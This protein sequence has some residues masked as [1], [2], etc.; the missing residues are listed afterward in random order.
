M[1]TTEEISVY[2]ALVEVEP[3]D[4]CQID[5]SEITGAAVRCYVASTNEEKARKSIRAALAQD[6]FKVVDVEWCV[7]ESEVE[8]E[9]PDDVTAKRLVAEAMTTDSVI[10]GEFH[11]WG[12]E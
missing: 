4:G 11:V 10:Y 8:W 12:P 1:N 2:V 5:P 6:C 9:N 3:M 7:N